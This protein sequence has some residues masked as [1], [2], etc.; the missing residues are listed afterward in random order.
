MEKDGFIPTYLPSLAYSYRKTQLS[1]VHV[2]N[3]RGKRQELE[4]PIRPIQSG[5]LLE[6][7]PYD[8]VFKRSRVLFCP[9][10]KTN[11]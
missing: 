2:D 11:G 7:T 6:G 1:I 8:M 3:L 4:K 9:S 5:G 10:N